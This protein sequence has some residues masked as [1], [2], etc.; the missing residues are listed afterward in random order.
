MF[1]VCFFCTDL[2]LNLSPAGKVVK[3]L[4]DTLPIIVEKTASG[5]SKVSWTKVTVLVRYHGSKEWQQVNKSCF[6]L[7]TTD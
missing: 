2:D 1:F 3:V 4:G 6:T 7:M 5:D